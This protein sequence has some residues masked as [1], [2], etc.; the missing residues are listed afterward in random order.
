[1]PT[2]KSNG[3]SVY[4]GNSVFK[5]LN[6]FLKKKKYSS[7]F[8]ICDDNTL[9]HCLPL[10][11]TACPA[12]A[13]AEIIE[14]E[15]GEQ[16]KALDISAN[17]W[18]TLL[19]RR[20]D[21]NSL[22]INL[23]GGMVSDLGGFCAAVY[24]RGISFIN[25]PTSLLAMA[26]ASVGGKTAIDFGGIKNSIGSF[27]QPAGVFVHPI[28][29]NTLPERHYI[30]GLAEVF[31]IALVSDK[32]FWNDLKKNPANKISTQQIAQSIA[33]KNKIVLKDPF[34]KSLRKSLNFGHSV[35]H[36]LEALLLGTKNELL[37]GEAVFIG[38]LAES[39]IAMQKKL[40]LKQQFDEIVFVLMQFFQFPKIDDE[41]SEA[42]I[43]LIR[44]DKKTSKNKL[45]F[46]LVSGIGQCKIDVQVNEGQIKKAIEFCYKTVI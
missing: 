13:N 8:I 42:I 11:I 1:M 2:I 19:E 41:N 39:H 28:F 32:N 20:A 12:L 16:S 3:Y 27:A 14:V 22:I 15:S 35:G 36:A 34:D 30:N 38:M 26:D 40:I 5:S 43:E 33:L 9:Q 24:K 45:R 6:A 4:I 7:H 23:G 44:N 46:A 17:I 29:L 18:H 37:H 31:K 25:V 21:S 10:L